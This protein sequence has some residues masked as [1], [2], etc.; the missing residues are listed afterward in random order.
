MTYGRIK[1]SALYN[2][3]KRDTETPSAFAVLSTIVK[4]EDEPEMSPRTFSLR[5]KLICAIALI[6][7]LVSFPLIYLGYRDAY[8]H[9]IDAA[10]DKFSNI[11]RILSDAAELSYLNAQTLVTEKVAIEK[12][13]ISAELGAIEKWLHEGRLFD[14]TPT[15]D[16]LDETWGTYAAVVNDAGEFM[17]LA[18]AIQ[19]LWR[20]DARDYLGVPFREFFRSSGRSMSRDDFTFFRVVTDPIAGKDMPY[21]TGLR[22]MKGYTALIL[23]ELDYFE[24]PY[25]TTEA[26]LEAQM[27]DTIRTIDIGPKTNVV[28]VKGDGRLIAERGTSAADFF[29]RRMQ[30][31]WLRPQKAGLPPGF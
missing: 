5:A 19:R 3:E 12:D 31:K 18:P 8:Q 25:K 23:Q 28:V 20:T 4:T 1:K 13:D 22:R 15:L 11:T 10:T 24:E 29:L 30:I 2:F 17:Y 26:T 7:S 21:L 16:F 9:S 27:K 6:V 14:M